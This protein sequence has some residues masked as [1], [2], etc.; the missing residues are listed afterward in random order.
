MKQLNCNIFEKTYKKPIVM[1]KV[2][3]LLFSLFFVN[4]I[5]SQENAIKIMNQTS[6]KEV[7]IKENRRIKIKTKDG[8]KI[9][10][11]FKIETNNFI[12]IKNKRIDLRD[13]EEIKRNSLFLSIFTSGVFLYGGTLLAGFSVVAG[14]FIDSSFLLFGIPAAGLIY[15]GIKPPN[16]QKNYTNKSN[17]TFELITITE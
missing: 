13:I 8:Q 7:V 6:K 11:R 1:K 10:G 14:V 12:L 2:M 17:W 4:L 5:F 16:F 9:S 15:A 3:F